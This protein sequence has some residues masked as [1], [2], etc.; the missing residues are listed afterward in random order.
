MSTGTGT[1]LVGR[2]CSIVFR[3]GVLRFQILRS[4]VLGS[5]LRVFLILKAISRPETSVDPTVTLI[6]LWKSWGLIPV[7]IAGQSRECRSTGSG[8]LPR[9]QRGERG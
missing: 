5:F 8:P 3:V 6:C 2:L 4:A 9:D 1:V 7:V